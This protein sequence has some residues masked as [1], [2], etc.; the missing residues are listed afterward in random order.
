NEAEL[1]I[2]QAKQQFFE[3]V[4]KDLVDARSKV[5]DLRQ[6]VTVA[7]DVLRR[8]DIV[9]PTTGTVQSLKVF[10]VGAVVRAGDA[11]LD[12]APEEDELIVQAQF[13]PIDV[14]N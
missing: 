3:Q 13:S 11:L 12:I 8:L 7:Q 4:I 9:A 1:Q 10:T 6:R 14:D 2:A 5:A